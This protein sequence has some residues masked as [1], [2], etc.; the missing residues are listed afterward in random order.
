MRVL[1]DIADATLGKALPGTTETIK[2]LYKLL[3]TYF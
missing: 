2:R 3:S 1:N